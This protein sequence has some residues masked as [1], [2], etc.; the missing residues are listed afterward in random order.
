MPV[1]DTNVTREVP[2]QPI[3][4]LVTRERSSVN[5]LS[6]QLAFRLAYLAL[7]ERL[8]IR[9]DPEG[10]EEPRDVHDLRAR[11]PEAQQQIPVDSELELGVDEPT[12]CVP[13]P[14]AP[15]QRLL[16]YV[17]GQRECTI[18]VFRQDPRADLAVALVDHDPI[19]VDDVDLGVLR[20]VASYYRQGARQQ[21]IVRVQ[22][23]HDLAV[24]PREAAVDG[25]GLSGVCSEVQAVSKRSNRRRTSTVLSV[26][27][28]SC[29]TY[30]RDG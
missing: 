2:V 12:H 27:P 30:S 24:R 13:D 20:E 3:E 15:E 9:M 19:A 7:D 17:V 22:P 4:D 28:P 1:V 26:E 25:I 21:E 29:T 10:P 18:I 14:A 5:S 6:Q 16:R 11:M 8:L 23:R